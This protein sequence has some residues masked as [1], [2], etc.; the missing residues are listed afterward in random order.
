MSEVKAAKAAA[1][2]RDPSDPSVKPKRTYSQLI[3][4]A[5]LNS[6]SRQVSLQSA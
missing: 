4:E 5:L 3:S 1:A 2:T 6:Q